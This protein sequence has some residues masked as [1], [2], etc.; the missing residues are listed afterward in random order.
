MF[1]FFLKKRKIT[2]PCKFDEIH[3]HL[4]A[5]NALKTAL[6]EETGCKKIFVSGPSGVGKKTMVRLA[7][8]NL[9][10]CPVEIDLTDYMYSKDELETF[11]D[12]L[13]G[14]QKDVSSKMICIIL[15]GLKDG[16]NYTD[17]LL[18][19]IFKTVVK[20]LC[21]IPVVIIYDGVNVNKCVTAF[22]CNKGEMAHVQLGY[23][24]ET[25]LTLFTKKAL[26]KATG[27]KLVIFHSN[28]IKAIVSQCNGTYVD[29]L[30]KVNESVFKNFKKRRLLSGS[31]ISLSLHNNNN[32]VIIDEIDE[33][34][35]AAIPWAKTCMDIS[36]KFLKTGEN[37]TDIDELCDRAE[38]MSL[39]MMIKKRHGCKDIEKENTDVCY[40]DD[41]EEGEQEGGE[42]EDKQELSL[43]K[44]LKQMHEASTVSMYHS[45]EA[46]VQD[47]YMTFLRTTGLVA[48]IEKTIYKLNNGSNIC[49]CNALMAR[50]PSFATSTLYPS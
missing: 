42:K 32:N 10:F 40:D 18:K 41:D 47:I 11:I 9:N 34:E 45:K 15:L 16:T 3:N 29:C 48:S 6:T 19:R 1:L 12:T 37:E 14:M 8:K 44:L 33:D 13:S 24:S 39:T 20:T 21:L 36:K 43:V 27:D 38:L 23:L 28:D 2:A 50:T 5:K 31:K 22:K 17:T 30:D 7:L 26:K 4:G 49:C 46:I 35:Q 25:E